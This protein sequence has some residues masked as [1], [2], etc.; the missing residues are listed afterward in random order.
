[1]S[2]FEIKGWVDFY[3]WEHKIQKEAM[4]KAKQK[5]GRR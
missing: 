1:M 2:T 4:Q 3:T 5:R